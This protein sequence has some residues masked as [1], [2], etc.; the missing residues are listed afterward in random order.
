MTAADRERWDARYSSRPSLANVK[1]PDWLTQQVAEM[2][3]GRALDVACGEGH[4]AVWL[5]E[6]DWQVMGI[7]ISPIA[8]AR[9]KQLAEARKVNATWIAADLDEYSLGEN[10]YD[11]ITVFRF[12]DR[13]LT[14]RLQAALRPGGMLIYET[15]LSP[16]AP[17]ETGHVR[18]PAYVLQSGELP[19]LFPDLKAEIYEEVK[20]DS[21]WRARL[22]GRNQ[23]YI[24]TR[25][26]TQTT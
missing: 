9:A 14:A 21:E 22:V 5:A 25:Q 4:L 6:R 18:N 16:P 19:R 15:L 12:L 17:R 3:P 8:L 1:P 11:L 26:Y 20:I 2:P 24:N 10:E 13:R 23:K 7:D